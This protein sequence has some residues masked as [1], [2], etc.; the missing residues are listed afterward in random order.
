MIARR[1]FASLLLTAATEVGAQGYRAQV[2]ASVQD[3]SFHGLR[4]DS[5]PA[6]LART[7]STGG[8]E[9]PD[10]FAVRCGAT[11]FCYYFRPATPIRV[12][13]A[14]LSASATLWGL[15]VTG[16]SVR[17]SARVLADFG[18]DRVWPGTHPAAQLLEG[19]AEYDRAPFT[20]RVGRQL[21][22]SRLEAIGFDGGWLRSRW[23]QRSLE[24][25]VY[26][27]WGL[28]QATALSPASSALN[29]LDE[30]R[31]RDRQLAGGAELGWANALADIRVE[32]RREIDPLDDYFV[33]E[34][35]ALSFTV[36]RGD[37]RAT[38]GGDY[39]IAE[40]NS[41]SADLSLS[42]LRP[43]YSL[44]GG[45]RRYRPYFN[46]WTLWG[47]FSPVPYSAYNGSAEWRISSSL[48]L[49]ARGE[50]Y[51]Y[52]DAEISTALVPHLADRGWRFSSGVS[53]SLGSRWTTDWN[54][55]IDRG[56]G[57]AGDYFDG[58]LRYAPN[59]RLSAS[60]YGGS[61]ARPLELRYYDAESKWVGARADWQTA[62]PRVWID[63]MVADDQRNRPDA[64]A[65]SLNQV[66][67][68]AGMSISF[69][70][71]ADRVPLPPARPAS[72]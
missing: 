52:D 41:G 62:W 42:Y 61:L 54:V 67:L 58:S 69:G 45:V 57:A 16:L 49:R 65:S 9:T 2:S 40:G 53:A 11:E 44:T 25:T 8:L 17:A 1:V 39:N 55:S 48:S 37:L 5:I 13:P 59:D 34:R 72:R 30:W 66:R 21:L 68:R 19:Y 38:G 63:G 70:S 27:G 60:V 46:L 14:S 36:R 20:A 3:L 18:R 28:A 35:A 51:W 43:K 64:A 15:G 4:A 22:S 10:G 29:P 50:R 24:L 31:P 7:S 33:S 6:A 47:A 23:E 56:P 26:G 12:T 71:A 32:Y